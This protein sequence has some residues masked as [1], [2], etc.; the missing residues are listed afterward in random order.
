[1][2]PGGKIGNPFPGAAIFPT[3]GTYVTIPQD[4]HAT[5]ELKWNVSYQRQLGQNWRASVNYLGTKSNH[6][7]GAHEIDPAV[8]TPGATTA[9]TNQRRVLYMLNP[10]QGALYS[11]IVQTDDGNTANYNGL[12]LSVEHRFANHFTW[13][14]NYTYSQCLS[15]Y[16]FGGEL[17]GNNY[18]NPNDRRAEYGSCNFDRRHIFNTSMV[19]ISAGIGNGVLNKVTANWEVSPI[20]SLYSVGSL[21]AQ[22][23]E[24]MF[25]LPAWAPIVR[26]WR[27]L[28]VSTLQG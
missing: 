22:R 5:Y 20:I 9:T 4:V 26:T 17:A 11:S 25:R 19:A 6:I 18:Q 1:M 28:A 15:T 3:A 10:V 27:S 14:A 21:S 2:Q 7:L 12:L 13:L 8:Y 16:D 23:L 24:R